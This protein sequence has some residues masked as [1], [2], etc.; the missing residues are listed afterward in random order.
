[1]ENLTPGDSISFQ[2]ANLAWPSDA[3][4]EDITD[5]FVLR[6]VNVDFPNGELSVITGE[7][8]SGMYQSLYEWRFETS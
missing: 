2:N 3:K 5:R 8:G 1:M 6:G 7:T 4:L